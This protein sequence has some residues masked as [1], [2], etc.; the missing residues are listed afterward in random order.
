MRMLQ[1]EGGVRMRYLRR[2]IWYFVSR[3]FVFL[4]ILGILTVTFYFAYNATNIYVIVKDGMA[5][6]AQVIMMD[7]PVSSLDNYFSASWIPRDGFL[8]NALNNVDPYRDCTVTGFDHRI[9]LSRMWCWPWE[10]TASAVITE[11][12]PAI[13]GKTSS[14]GGVPDWP[15]ARYS[16]ILAREDGHWKIKNM[17]MMELLNE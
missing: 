6:R 3:L 15:D 5:R 16:V 7:E 4:L 8:Q 14:A 13:D 12:I 2:L 1:T 11:R 9:S 10:D 17:T